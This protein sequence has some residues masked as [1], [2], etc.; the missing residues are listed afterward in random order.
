MLFPEWKMW[1]QFLRQTSHG[2]LL[3]ALEQSHPVK[4]RASI[5]APPIQLHLQTS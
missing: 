4:V 3:D 1:T 5:N 2:L